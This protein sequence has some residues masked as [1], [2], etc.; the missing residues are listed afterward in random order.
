MTKIIVFILI[1][2][3]A[4]TVIRFSKSSPTPKQ[5]PTTFLAQTDTQ[6]NVT[7]VV[8]PV[9]LSSSAP[10]VFTVNFETHSVNL[11]FDVT[12]IATL[13]DDKGNT[14]KN[15]TWQGSPAGGH[16]RNG[17]LIFDTLSQNITSV[18]LTFKN[19]AGISARTF[20]W[21]IEGKSR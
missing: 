3:T 12:K 16:H 13:T 15:P 17:Q 18:T 14:Y 7:V 2:L 11:D 5:T 21:N 10:A 6:A 9:Q 1:L 20:T 8:K 19:V 4:I